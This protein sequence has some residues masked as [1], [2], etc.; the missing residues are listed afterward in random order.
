MEYDARYAHEEARISQDGETVMLFDYQ[1]FCIYRMSGELVTQVELPDKEQIYDQQF[2][3]GEGDSW[4]EVIWYDGMVRCYSARD[5]GLILEEVREAPS[6]D[7]YEEFYTSKYQITS[8]L[9]GTPEVY[10]LETGKLV[11]MLEQ[12]SYLTY[13]TEEGNYLITEYIS[14]EGERYG[15]VLDEKFQTLAYLPNLCDEI[16]RAHV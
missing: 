6:K 12:D 7:L 2:V 1:G 13:V 15:L 5:G 16:G 14:A 9:H 3:K 11:A 10:S 4:L 8:P